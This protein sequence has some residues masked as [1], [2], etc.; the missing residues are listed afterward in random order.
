MIRRGRQ[1]KDHAAEAALFGRRAL[2]GLLLVLAGL[3]GL[4]AWY[5][6]LQVVQHAEF[7]T[8][9]EA[10]RVRLV[11]VAPARGLIYDRKGRLLADNVAAWRLDAVPE[12][13][14]DG[15]ALLAKLQR[16]VA[17]DAEQRVRF[18]RDYRNAR[19]FKPVTIKL[20]VSDEEAARFAVDRWRFPGVELVPYLGRV[21]P[22]GALFAHVVGYVGRIDEKDQA[23]LGD[24]G[25]AYTHT[26]K[27]GLERYYEAQ[28]RGKPGFRRLETNVDGRTVRAL[29]T[30]P[31]TPGTDL[32]LS[33]DIDLQR[34]MVDAFAE[35]E[36]TAV[37][38]DPRTG[39]ILA[40]VSLPSYDPNLFV[41]GI[42]HADYQALN[43]N[44]SR[45]QFN[46]LVLGGVAPGSTIK[47]LTALAG[48][49]SG[50]RRPE[51]RVLSTGVFRLPGMR[52]R[53][54][55]DGVHGWTDARKSIYES[56]NTYYYKLALDLGVQRYDEYMERYG[57]G[58]KTGI[59][60]AGEIE[61]IVPSPASKMKYGKQRWYPGDLV[62]SSI[63]QGLWKVTP[64][65]LARGVAAIA[66]DGR[67]RRPHLV[68][69][70]RPA[71]DAPWQALPQPAAVRISDR[72]DNVRV[73][74]EGMEMTTAGSGTAARVFR[75]LAYRSG[76][77]T[78]TA[79]VVNRRAAAVDPRSLP[80]WQRHR[81]LYIGFAPVDEP[82]IAI[83]VAVEGGGFGAD[84]AAPIARKVFDA[85]LLGKAVAPKQAD[86]LSVVAA[87]VAP[88]RPD[89]TGVQGSPG[90]V[91]PPQRA[92]QL[93]R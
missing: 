12:R 16:V 14:G 56:V 44:P 66:D 93:A 90:A 73:V 27:T 3:G 38:V 89:F 67:M 23:A 59:D 68:A 57:F 20:R 46:R 72:P 88:P 35:L 42:S 49:D 75:G 30:V 37:A 10:N 9:S 17:L 18:L 91:P 7:A 81:A 70:Q 64:L 1:L 85:W 26:G 62:N 71:F 40:M 45:P 86:G 92:E 15:E 25:G 21:Y 79:Q 53:G 39:E 52:G 33:V 28:L 24:S 83:A 84:S 32:R 4:A 76:G 58:Q 65:Q 41:N 6:R 31:A 29:D 60:L 13:A 2:V 36:G 34:A 5:F 54:W 80:L 82:A 61:G 19:P 43:D 48:L 47:P 50:L 11:P 55:L 69:A 87:G 78:G 22:Q 51:D 77:K 63:G 8:R 74:Q